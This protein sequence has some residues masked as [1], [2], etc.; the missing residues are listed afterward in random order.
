MGIRQRAKDTDDRTY[1]EIQQSQG[2]LV[3][4]DGSTWLTANAPHTVS[5][6]PEIVHPDCETAP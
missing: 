3:A 2:L 5:Q 4:K 6:N 1:P